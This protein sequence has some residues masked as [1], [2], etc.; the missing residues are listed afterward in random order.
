MGLGKGAYERLSEI[1]ISTDDV[2]GSNNWIGISRELDDRGNAVLE[3]ILTPG[4]PR[5][6][7]IFIARMG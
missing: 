7:P 1:R 4:M 2:E 5:I 3:H 6:C